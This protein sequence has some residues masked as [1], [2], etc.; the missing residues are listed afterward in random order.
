[1]R[2]TQDQ[3]RMSS[4]AMIYSHRDIVRAV[5][6]VGEIMDEFIRRTSS[7]ETCS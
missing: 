7:E 2:A 4:L 3:E 6:P 5:L 1:M